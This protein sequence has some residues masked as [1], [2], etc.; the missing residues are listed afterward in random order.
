MKPAVPKSRQVAIEL[1]SLLTGIIP[2]A[3]CVPNDLAVQIWK[4]GST[5]LHVTWQLL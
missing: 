1:W 2:V 4:G 5:L 3:A